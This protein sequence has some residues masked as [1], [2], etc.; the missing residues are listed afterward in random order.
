MLSIVGGLFLLRILNHIPVPWVD[1]EMLKNANNTGLLAFAN[2]FNGMVFSSY[3]F[4]SI[5]ISSYIT[6]S[7]LLQVLGFIVKPIHKLRSEPG[8]AKIIK[9]ITAILGIAIAFILSFVT[10]YS[11]DYQYHVLLDDSWYVFAIIGLIHAACSGICIYI[12]ESITETGFCEGIALIIT[13]NILA[14]L[15]SLFKSTAD[16]YEVGVYD[17]TSMA[18]LFAMVLFMFITVAIM[19]RSERH[20]PVRYIK[21][22]ANQYSLLK[23]DNYYKIKFNLAGIMPVVFAAYTFQLIAW[24]IAV[25]GNATALRIYQNFSYGTTPYIII[26]SIL[27]VIFGLFY[28]YAIV[29]VQELAYFFQ[30]RGGIIPGIRQGRDTAVFLRKEINSLA[31]VGALYLALI[32]AIPFLILRQ[33]DLN[34][35][36]TTS[37]VILMGTAISTIKTMS[38]EIQLAE[39]R[40]F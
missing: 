15:P 34:L 22:N 40:K 10:T 37:I 24:A 25:S 31:A 16:K 20:I 3:T 17:N 32:T 12:G 26:S 35:I 14:R 19:E 7:I 6:A 36:E 1:L 27:I 23:K 11:L 38:V 28:T 33:Y 18:V 29:D 9:K 5:G 8:G 30:T 2:M 21:G 4:G 13:S 39:V